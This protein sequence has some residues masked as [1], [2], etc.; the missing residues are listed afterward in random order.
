MRPTQ[1]RVNSEIKNWLAAAL[2]SGSR[3]EGR[4]SEEGGR[5]REGGGKVDGKRGNIGR[6]DVGEEKG[7]ERVRVEKRGK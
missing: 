1:L 4:G 6:E 3:G 5:E 2:G 7:E